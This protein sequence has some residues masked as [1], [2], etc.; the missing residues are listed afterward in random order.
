MT[1]PGEPPNWPYTVPER[2]RCWF[3]ASIPE[4]ARVARKVITTKD[5][6]MKTPCCKAV[7]KVVGNRIAY[8]HFKT[9][10]TKE[11]FEEAHENYFLHCPTCQKIWTF[12][13]NWNI[14]KVDFQ[15]DPDGDPDLSPASM[16]DLPPLPKTP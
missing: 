16:V 10:S 3:D 12:G 13:Y 1:E 7:G 9:D 4:I 2:Y 6:D 11:I 5:G 15:E 14:D 8:W